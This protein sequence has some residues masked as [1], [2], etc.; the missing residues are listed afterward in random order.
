VSAAQLDLLAAALPLATVALRIRQARADPVLE[1]WRLLPLGVRCL[2][3]RGATTWCLDRVLAY[4]VQQGLLDALAA[5]P[6]DESVAG[7]TSGIWRAE[8]DDFPHDS[9]GRAEWIQPWLDQLDGTSPCRHD[10]QRH[11]EPD[12]A[13]RRPFEALLE[14]VAARVAAGR[15]SIPYRYT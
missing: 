13:W 2:W 14:G 8:V 15:W 3:N 4:S 11:L 9:R 5:V 6:P 1:A 12:M 10:D 7:I